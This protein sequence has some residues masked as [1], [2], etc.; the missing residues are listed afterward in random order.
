MQRPRNTTHLSSICWSVVDL[1]GDAIGCGAATSICVCGKST[2]LLRSFLYQAHDNLRF[3]RRLSTSAA[4]Q[5]I[6]PPERYFDLHDDDGLST[7]VAPQRIAQGP[8]INFSPTYLHHKHATSFVLEAIREGVLGCNS[9]LQSRDFSGIAR[10]W[11][12]E[13][14]E[15]QAWPSRW[16]RRAERGEGR[17]Q[18]IFMSLIRSTVCPFALPGR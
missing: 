8:L 2:S 17:Y 10:L 18:V 9:T 3:H 13:L 7:T 5:R 4:P 15:L 11:R 16:E 12:V 6:A 14:R 1:T